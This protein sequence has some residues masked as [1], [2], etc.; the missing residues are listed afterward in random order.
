MVKFQ[1]CSDIHLEFYDSF[2]QNTTIE[3]FFET[4]IKPGTA[5]YLILPGDICQPH[6]PLFRQFFEW[7]SKHWQDVFYVT[8]NHEYYSSESPP[9]PMDF[10]E[11][12]LA[13]VLKGL[14]NVHWLHQECP[15][16]TI[17]RDISGTDITVV[18]T[19]LWTYIDEEDERDIKYHMMDYRVIGTPYGVKGRR[20]IEPYEISAMHMMQKQNLA[21]RIRTIS[22]RGRRIVVITHH[23]PSF[24]LIAQCFQESALNSC[25]AVACDT[26]IEMPG[27]IAWFYGHTHDVRKTLLSNCICAVNAFGYPDEKKTEFRVDAVVDL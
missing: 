5:P 16:E 13:A 8:G 4:I 11:D 7:C 25:F 12:K 19:T 14:N 15:G 3:K 26:L 20:T 1:Y 2:H 23:V 17:S 21:N 27:V 24:H 22:E 10:I 9:L 6:L 18:G